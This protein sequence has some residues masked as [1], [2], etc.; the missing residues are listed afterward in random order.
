MA[1][2]LPCRGAAP[3]LIHAASEPEPPRRRRTATAR[4]IRGQPRVPLVKEIGTVGKQPAVPGLRREQGQTRPPPSPWWRLRATGIAASLR[5]GRMNRVYAP[6]D[7][8][9]SQI[10]P[11]EL[12]RGERVRTGLRFGLSPQMIERRRTG[13]SQSGS[14]VQRCGTRARPRPWS[15]GASGDERQAEAGAQWVPGVVV[16]LPRPRALLAVAHAQP[17]RG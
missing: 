6:R 9:S 12:T 10:F 1:R 13:P 5:W 16:E 3:Q 7:V 8:S 14:A 2:T 15:C 17:G 4:Q 11:C